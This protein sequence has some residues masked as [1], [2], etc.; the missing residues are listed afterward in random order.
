[1]TEL[2]YEPRVIREHANRLN[3]RADS[4][5]LTSA[6]IGAVI[7]GFFGAVPLTSLGD[8]WPIPHQFGFGTLL[9]GVLI[10]ALLYVNSFYFPLRQLA[11]VWAPLQL[12]LAGLDRI[13]AVLALE[14]NMEVVAAGSGSAGPLLVFDRVGFSYPG[15]QDVLAACGTPLVAARGGKVVEVV[16][17]V[18]GIDQVGH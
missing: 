4:M 17:D 6:I 16:N 11:A 18:G 9:A 8:S 5:G 2:S 14:S 10:G 15:G 7:G 12:A 3:R 1:V 13:S